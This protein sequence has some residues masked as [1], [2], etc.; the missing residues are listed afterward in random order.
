MGLNTTTKLVQDVFSDVRRTFGDEASV[1]ITDDDLLR[2]IN[3]AQREILISNQ[4]LKTI[5]VADVVAGQSEYSLDTLN[6]VSIQS[7]HFNGTKLEWHSFQDAEEYIMSM[8]PSK[9]TIADPTIWYEW[10]GIINL[11]PIPQTSATGALKI[12]YIKEPDVV[13]AN[14]K[15]I[16]PDAY[17]ENVLQFCLSKAYELDEDPQNS[18]FK[19]GQFTE[20]LNVLSEQE[21]HPEI[22]TYPRISVLMEDM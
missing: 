7:I 19:L 21:N 17:Y 14:S 18:Q 9:T 5:S 22:D 20:R 6:I 3:T 15:L 12:Y 1:Q 13:V 16:V 4:I 8:D 2:W 11:Y 10:G